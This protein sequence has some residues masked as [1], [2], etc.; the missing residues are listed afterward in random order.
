MMQEIILFGIGLSGILAGYALTKIAPEEIKPGEKYFHLF[1]SIVFAV[2]SLFISYALFV[3][4]RY[5][6]L[7]SLAILALM[8]LAFSVRTRTNLVYVIAYVLFG[9]FYFFLGQSHNP[10]LASLLFVYG[11]PVGTLLFASNDEN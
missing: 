3:S 6:I 11:L 8:W 4:K 2:L 5:V 7:F 9:F 1:A 10:I